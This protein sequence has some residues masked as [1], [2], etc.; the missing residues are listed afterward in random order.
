[1]DL[2][3]GILAQ[4]GGQTFL[5][6][7]GKGAK[8][9][10]FTTK[11]AKLSDKQKKL[12]LDFAKLDRRELQD[13]LGLSK[14]QAT[15]VMEGRKIDV[16]K[17][18]ANAQLRNATTKQQVAAADLKIKNLN[19]QIKL[20]DHRQKGRGYKIDTKEQINFAQE[21]MKN[22]LDL[23]N[24]SGAHKKILSDKGYDVNKG[25][26]FSS[27]GEDILENMANLRSWTGSFNTAIGLNK[28]PYEAEQTATTE[29]LKSLPSLTK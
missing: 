14:Q 26:I 22:I 24:L 19:T 9:S 8:D 28:N 16:Q 20:M 5:E 17:R 12:S 7:I 10:K 11:L 23:D 2:G 6:A 3:F 15:M 21:A 1:M 18:V 29:F 4:P 13:E 27:S 25:R